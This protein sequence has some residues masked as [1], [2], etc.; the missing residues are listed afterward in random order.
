MLREQTKG[1]HNTNIVQCI[2]SASVVATHDDM[3]VAS[4]AA[5]TTVSTTLYSGSSTAAIDSI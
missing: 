1:V 4:A 2:V 5:V 3:T